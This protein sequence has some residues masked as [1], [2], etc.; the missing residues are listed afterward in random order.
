M[1]AFLISG[2]GYSFMTL[3]LKFFLGLALSTGV[4]VSRKHQKLSSRDYIRYYGSFIPEGPG[5]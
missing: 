5:T 1:R 3:G 2:R 4:S